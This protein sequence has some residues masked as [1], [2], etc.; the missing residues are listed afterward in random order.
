VRFL[1]IRW[2]VAVSVAA[3]VSP[4]SADDSTLV[5]LGIR[6]MEGDDEFANKLTT[7]LRQQAAKLPD[8][9]TSQRVISL[10]QMAL[11]YDCDDLDV[12]CLSKI[13]IGLGVKRMIYGVTQR[14]SARE[15]YDF[16][17]FL[18]LF[19]SETGSIEAS[20]SHI[21]PFSKSEDSALE[22][23]TDALL[24][25]LVSRS[26]SAGGMVVRS[27]IQGAR[28][29]VDNQQIGTLEEGLL[30]ING[31][32]PGEH[33]VDI[34]A[35]GY[36]SRHE[37]A[38]VSEGKITEVN[39][40]LNP[41]R[42]GPTEVVIEDRTLSPQPRSSIPRWLP[43]TLLGVSGVSLAGMIASWVWIDSIEHDKDYEDYRARVSEKNPGVNVCHEAENGLAYAAPGTTEYGKFSG[44]RRMCEHAATLE[45]M[46]F[47][48]LGAA[49]V[50]GGVGAY[51]LVRSKG[52]KESEYKPVAQPPALTWSVE[53]EVTLGLLKLS[54][55]LAF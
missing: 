31:L 28:V 36:Q 55:S 14:T 2:F 49:L 17:V 13:A 21:I 22:T 35:S 45:V 40:T 34:D 37:T 20:A 16:L 51:L 24:V 25:V 43:V 6:S 54:A 4:V 42:I 18:T 19:N 10:D 5:I 3:A 39:G 1:L 52:T 44:V 27:N 48:M 9:E 38:M 8:F 47:V 53:P 23:S 26:T 46:Q 29:T 33:S 7:A 32:A 15:P 50:S 11:A 30:T 12:P 41:A